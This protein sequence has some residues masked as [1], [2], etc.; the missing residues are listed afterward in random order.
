VFA[1][2]TSICLDCRVALPDGEAC[3]WLSH[4]STALAGDCAPLIE[5]VWGRARER[6][7]PLGAATA[8]MVP[9]TATGFRGRIAQGP[10]AR[11]PMRDQQAVGWALE[12]WHHEAAGSPIMLRDGATVGFAVTGDDGRMLVVPSTGVRMAIDERAGIE[13][14]RRRIG[15]YLRELAPRA[16]EPWPF[17]FDEVRMVVLSAEDLV[18]VRAVAS[19]SPDPRA[20]TAYRDAP[21]SILIATGPAWVERHTG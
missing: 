15:G 3:T 4:R 1:A 19:V 17:P 7:R 14:N 20:A 11:V 13:R 8:P 12:V 18:T 10:T 6:D 2:R 9:V 21:R 16:A 5:T